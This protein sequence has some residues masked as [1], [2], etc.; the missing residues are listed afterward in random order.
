MGQAV[1][2]GQLAVV[3]D[4]VVE[5]GGAEDGLGANWKG[6]GKELL[7]TGRDWGGLEMGWGHWEELG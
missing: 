7:G 4:E 3:V 5:D 1:L 6:T 2:G